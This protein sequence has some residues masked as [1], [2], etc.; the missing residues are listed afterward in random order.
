MKLR[1]RPIIFI[2]IFLATLVFYALSPSIQTL[3]ILTLYLLFPVGAALVGLYASRIY[4]FRS[5]N[6]RAILLI[7]GGLVCWG[8]GESIGYS[9]QSYMGGAPFPS[10]ADFFYLVGYPLFAAGIYQGFITSGIKLK[11]VK[12][13]L[14]IA[15]L[16]V[17]LVLAVLV[18]YFGVYQAYDPTADL[19]ANIVAIFYGLADLVLIVLSLLTILVASEY[20]DGKLASFWKTIALGFF[21]FLIA[22]ILFAMYGDQYSGDIQPYTYIDLI[23]IA[24][25]MFLAY[26]MLDN[27]IHV[28]AVQKKIKLMLKQRNNPVGA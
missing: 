1:I 7:T 8:I 6:G 20:G 16:L 21:L 25:Y 13:S 4:G 14:L 27:Y 28:T 22:D 11:Q 26:A 12:K 23:W 2:A 5:A 18:G 24:A 19:A 15:V 3:P 10:M 17:S 9:L